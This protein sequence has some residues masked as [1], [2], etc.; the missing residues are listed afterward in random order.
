[1]R[2]IR[3]S[4]TRIFWGEPTGCGTAA[5]RLTSTKA[6]S[7]E[8]LVAGA[9]TGMGSGSCWSVNAIQDPAINASNSAR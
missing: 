4:R 1:M 3:A 5:I 2:P 9:L 6:R 8:K 7:P